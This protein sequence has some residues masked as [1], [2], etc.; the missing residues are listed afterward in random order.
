MRSSFV[1][2]LMIGVLEMLIVVV[3]SILAVV[4]AYDLSTW[5]TVQEFEMSDRAPE[6]YDRGPDNLRRLLR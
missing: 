3:V 6:C 2:L 1:F 4:A 5:L